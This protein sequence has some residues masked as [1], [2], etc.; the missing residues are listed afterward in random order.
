[1]GLKYEPASVTTTVAVYEADRVDVVLVFVI[2]VHLQSK[3]DSHQ[4]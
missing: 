2:L 3:F 1:M 4:S